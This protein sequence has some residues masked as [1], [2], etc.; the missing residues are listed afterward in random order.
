MPALGEISYSR[1]ACIDAVRD[2]YKFLILLHL[3]GHYLVEP[4][5]AGWPHITPENARCLGK[6]DEVVALLRHLPYLR[7]DITTSWEA[8]GAPDTNFAD[9]SDILRMSMQKS[10]Q[11]GE[12]DE[13]SRIMS[14]GLV[15]EEDTVPAHVISLT[16]GA[17]NTE[18]FLLDTDLGVI[19]WLDC[20]SEIK[21]FTPMDSYPERVLDDAWD[22]AESDEEALWRDCGAWAVVDF[23]EMLKHQFCKLNFY[24]VGEGEVKDVWRAGTKKREEIRETFRQHGWPDFET[25]RIE[26]CLAAIRVMY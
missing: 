26:E 23:F 22:Y 16:Y 21:G 8:Q 12:I 10:W 3:P 5:E 13:D 14:E 20:R 1:Q 19:Y 2:Y 7:A 9:W 11:Q 25:Y 18:R 15:F 6:T 17:G 24:P 4:P